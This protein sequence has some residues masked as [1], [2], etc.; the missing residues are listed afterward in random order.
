MIAIDNNQLSPGKRHTKLACRFGVGI[1][2]YRQLHPTATC[3]DKLYLDY[4]RLRK[5]Y[6]HNELVILEAPQ[7]LRT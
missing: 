2:L 4:L 6:A 5:R 1:L 7:T 3:S